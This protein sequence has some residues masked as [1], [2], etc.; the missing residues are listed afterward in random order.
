MGMAYLGFERV[1][2]GVETFRNSVLEADLARNI[3]RDLIS[4]RSLA[5]YFV[6]RQGRGRQGGAGGRSQ[7]EGRHRSVDEGHHQSGAAR[8]GHAPGA[9]I[10]HLH[11]DF[12]RYPQGQGRERADRAK[13][14]DAQRQHRCVTS[15]TISPATPKTRAA[16]DHFGA[17]KVTDAISGGD[18]AR[19]YLRHQ[20]G[21]GGRRQRAGAPEIRRELAEG[22]FV[23]GRK[24]SCRG[25]RRS[26]HCWRNT[27]KSLTKLV[28]NSK[29]IDELTLEMTE[30]AAAINKG[31][32]RDEVGPAGRSEEARMPNRMRPSA[33]PS[34]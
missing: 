7:P 22:D 2:S 24:D 16:G 26:R 23:E 3:D 18:G 9:G 27:G 14:A 19:Q 11:Q 34:S 31:S 4:Y 8:S 15:S 28:E 17:K 5:R 1:S 33:R 10:P 13:P 30:S 12:R 32:E 25:S 20:F 29:E 21:A 6:D